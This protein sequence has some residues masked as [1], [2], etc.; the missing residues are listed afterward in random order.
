MKKISPKQLKEKLHADQ[1]AILDV[2]SEEKF[3]MGH[4]KHKNAENIHVPKADIFALEETDE[5]VDM[6]FSPNTEVIITCT[7]GNSARRCTKILSDKGYNAVLLEDGMTAWN[8]SNC[9][10]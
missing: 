9:D 6:P 1:V 3:Q 2:R 8:K 7:T 5:N 4:L 10:L